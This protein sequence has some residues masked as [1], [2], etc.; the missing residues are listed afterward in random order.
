VDDTYGDN[1]G[2][3]CMTKVASAPL[4]VRWLASRALHHLPLIKPTVE[5]NEVAQLLALAQRS[6]EQAYD[7]SV[8]DAGWARKTI[9]FDID[10]ALSELARIDVAIG[11]YILPDVIA[12]KHF[13]RVYEYPYAVYHLR[14]IEKHGRIL[15]CGC[16]TTS[17][18]FYLAKQGFEV[19]AVDDWLPCLEKVANLKKQ[20]NLTNLNP[21]FGSVFKL[22]FAD[23]YFDGATCISVIEHALLSYEN[24][25]VI[26]KGAINELLRVLKKG[27]PLVL[28]FDVN[29]GT[30]HRHL[31][32]SEYA[33]LCEILKIAPTALPSDRLYSS[34]TKE[35]ALM[36]EDIAVYC[37]TIIKND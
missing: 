29:F 20:S 33:K 14:K 2:G 35:G 3:E 28:T 16:G 26:L 13:S 32:P 30:E 27:A 25:V 36:G 17:F 11:S 8:L 5:R 12:T 1:I 22:P 34:D 7:F 23:S 24:P 31:V 18:Q 19:H 21:T 9:T 6:S 10:E 4:K 37:V 15:D